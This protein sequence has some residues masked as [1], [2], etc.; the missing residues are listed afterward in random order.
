[1]GYRV[2]R[3][4]LR[5]HGSFKRETTRNEDVGAINTIQRWKIRS[6]TSLARGG[7]EVT[8]QLLLCNGA[9]QVPKTAPAERRNAKKGLPGNHWHGR[10]RRLRSES[11]PNRTEWKQRQTAV[12]FTASSRHEYAQT[13]ESQKSVQ[14]TKKVPM[15]S[16][17]DKLL[18][19][20]DLLRS[21]IGIVFWFREHLIA[22]SADIEAMFLQ[23]AVPGD[24]NRCLR[25][26]WREDS[27]QRV[28]VYEY[29]RH[30][31]GAKSSPACADNAVNNEI[32]VRTVQ[33]NFYMDDFL[34]S[35]RTPQPEFTRKS[36]T[37]SS[38]VDSIWRNG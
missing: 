17:K 24:D 36:D 25:F 38:K 11:W 1:M 22:F 6:W 4:K 30:F 35:V 8:E 34:K 5:C 33:R 31:F 7:S 14:H 37:S 2:L 3:S 10:Q 13:W 28:D 20:P 16:S 19:R 18:S 29:T 27:E 15:C 32:L 9:T 21:L 23:V 26:L 12:V